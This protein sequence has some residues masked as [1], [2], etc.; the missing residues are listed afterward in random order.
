MHDLDS[1]I[2]KACYFKDMNYLPYIKFDQGITVTN[3]CTLDD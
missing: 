1:D 3:K 2:P